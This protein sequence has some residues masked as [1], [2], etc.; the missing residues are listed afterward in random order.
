[1]KHLRDDP[2]WAIQGFRG[3]GAYDVTAAF[4]EQ[5]LFRFLTGDERGDSQVL[6]TGTASPQV[7][8][9]WRAFRQE[10]RQ[11]LAGDNDR[12]HAEPFGSYRIAC[13][14]R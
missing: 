13:L 3:T 4:E 7:A 5:D 6:Y 11:S 9:R 14:K 2:N 12:H 8:S 1:L 10:D